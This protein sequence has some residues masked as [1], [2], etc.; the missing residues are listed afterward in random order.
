MRWPR[1]WPSLRHLALRP[2]LILAFI[3][4][5]AMAGLC[6]LVGLAFVNRMT[7]TVSGLVDVTTPLLVESV[8]LV[9][10]AHRIR[11]TFLVAIER[12]DDLDPLSRQL[13]DLHAQTHEQIERLKGLSSLAGI[14]LQ[15]DEIERLEAAFH[16]TLGAIIEASARERIAAVTF[17]ARQ[18]A[19]MASYY[20]LQ[21]V[22]VSLVDRAEGEMMKAEDE[23]KV[24]VQTRTATVDGLGDR[25]SEVLA[26]TYP[27]VQNASWSRSK[28]PTAGSRRP[29]R[30]SCQR[31]RRATRAHSVWPPR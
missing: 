25:M 20:N 22:L 11:S 14:T 7:T 23:T 10:N 29:R 18:G 31:S 13:S 9:E 4:I 15:F 17:H 6:G 26:G 30:S 5:A 3:A 1:S 12:G 16:T 21:R 2:K 8:S 24:Q 27:I 28:I 19:L